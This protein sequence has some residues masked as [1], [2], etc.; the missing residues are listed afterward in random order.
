MGDVMENRTF[1]ALVKGLA[2]ARSRRSLL[3]AVVGLGSAAVAGS[4]L[5]TDTEAARRGF[6]G[7]TLPFPR[8]PEPGPSC[9][10][11]T[12]YGCNSCVNGVCVGDPTDCYVHE[13][14]ASVCDPD[15]GCSYP[16]DCRHG[17]SCCPAHHI[18]DTETGQCECNPLD[19]CC[20]VQ[21]SNCL[22]CLDGACIPDN[23]LCPAVPAC[24]AMICQANGYCNEVVDC[25]TG[26]GTPCCGQSGTCEADGQC[27][28]ADD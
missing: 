21:C 6:S 11:N 5:D 3:R 14:M 25:R 28:N 12:C 15:G 23:S 16:F 9:D 17:T 27:S 26:N 7:P 10:P 1:D 13:C 22:T 4:W 20:N 8:T 19:K 2:Q 18:C 24:F